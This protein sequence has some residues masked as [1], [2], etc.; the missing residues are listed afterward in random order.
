MD[1]RKLGDIDARIL[2]Y[3]EMNRQGSDPSFLFELLEQIIER[4]EWETLTDENG[5]PL[6]SFQRLVEEPMPVGIG[7]SLD[8]L[9]A[10]LRI[11]HRY[12]NQNP[13]WR[14]RMIRLKRAIEAEVP[15]LQEHG[16]NRYTDSRGSNTTSKSNG[17]G[18]EY[19]IGRLKRDRPDLAERV[20]TGEMSASVAAVEAGFRKR[21]V[22]F[23]PSDVEGT[24]KKLLHEMETEAV[25][26]LIDLLLE[27]LEPSNE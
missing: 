4:R 16:T 15:E 13:K 22:T 27:G 5:E 19:I 10:L 8:K 7:Q 26:A 3:A 20:L 11:E 21:P 18:K 24:A 23:F 9:R 25:E 1:R 17:R 14:E 6:G 2:L 12:E